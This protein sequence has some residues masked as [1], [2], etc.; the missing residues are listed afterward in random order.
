MR[1]IES[2]ILIQAAV[3][4]F[5]FS[6]LVS[7]VQAEVTD[8]KNLEVKLGF[9][10]VPDECTCEGEDISPEIGVQGLSTTSMAVIVDDPDARSTFTHWII[11]N[12]PPVDVIPGAIPKNATVNK[13]FW[14][15]RGRTLSDKSGTLALAHLQESHT[16]ISSASLDWTGRWTL[17]RALLDR[18]WRKQWRAMCYKKERLWPLMEGDFP[19]NA[20]QNSTFFLAP[21]KCR[22]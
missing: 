8:M 7:G 10:R 21:K 20:F 3:A 5:A 13:P 4:A 9:T 6:V 17:S 15:C 11:W 16:G 22:I 12:I 18:I 14:H 2:G 1:L 19:G